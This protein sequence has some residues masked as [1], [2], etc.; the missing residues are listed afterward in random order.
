MNDAFFHSSALLDKILTAI[1][2]SIG[3]FLNSP[4]GLLCLKET[5]E[6][7]SP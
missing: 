3:V 1:P 7:K 4:T 2:S 6:I 5:I